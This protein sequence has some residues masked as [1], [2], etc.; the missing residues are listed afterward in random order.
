MTSGSWP[1]V[2]RLLV[3]RLDNI[4]DVI[5]LGP[6]LR[7][8]RQALAQAS[9]TLMASPAGAQAAPLLPWIDDLIIHRA[10]WQDVSGSLAHDPG[11][12]QELVQTLQE[13]RFDAALI[14]TSFS[15]SPHP[16]AYACYLAGIPVRA[17]Q[18][19]EFG[20]AVLS[21]WIKPPPD[22]TH[23]VDRNLFLL[24]SAGFRPEER[25]LSLSVPPGARITAD[26]L[27]AEVGIQP[28]VPFIVLAP[29]ASC[30]ARR[31][32]PVRYAAVA[33]Q[34]PSRTGMHVVVVGSLRESELVRPILDPAHDRV[35]SLVGQTSIP[36]LAAVIERSALVI[37]N[38]SGPMHIADAFLR[39]TLV[40]YSG[41]E[42]ESQWRPRSAPATLLKRSVPCSPCYNF[43]CPY[44]MECLD[45]PPEEVLAEASHMLTQSSLRG[46]HNETHLNQ[47]SAFSASPWQPRASAVNQQEI[48]HAKEDCPH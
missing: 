13:R 25:Q 40:L 10:L 48:K 38:N 27:L 44:N 5:M 23:Q 36:Q 46:A 15:Q 41:T 47:F 7:T 29:G 19:K 45:V 43:H 24:E 12:E 22:E 26:R 1:L 18:S 9:I 42:Y 20:G 34:L 39:P 21:Q 28:G 6:S 31:Y 33:R 8:L 4:G 3:V 14:F 17:G 16:A 35:V 37:A 32:D 2:H 30:A 11:R